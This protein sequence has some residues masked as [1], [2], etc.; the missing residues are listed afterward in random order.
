MQIQC[1][2]YVGTRVRRHTS[3]GVKSTWGPPAPPI[4]SIC[5]IF[6][7]IYLAGMFRDVKKFQPSTSTRTQK[8]ICLK[9]Q[10]VP[11]YLVTH[12]RVNEILHKCTFVLHLII[13]TTLNISQNNVNQ[14]RVGHSDIVRS[15]GYSI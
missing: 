14:D 1:K 15:N 3:T 12:I 6:L 11:G 13:S 7:L 8:N 10:K 2:I 4:W 5:L 9:L